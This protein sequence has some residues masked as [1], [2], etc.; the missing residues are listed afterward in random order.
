MDILFSDEDF[1]VALQSLLDSSPVMTQYLFVTATLPIEIY[2]KLIEA[3]PD[4][5]VIMGP[6]MHHISSGLE[7]VGSHFFVCFYPVHVL[8]LL[9][10]PLLSPIIELELDKVS[11]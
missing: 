9:L 3:F 1:K 4:T 10:A 7:E 2:N 8:L 11:I 5:K 6:G